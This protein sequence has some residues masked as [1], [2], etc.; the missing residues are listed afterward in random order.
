MGHALAKLSERLGYHRA[1]NSFEE[2]VSEIEFLKEKIGVSIPLGGSFPTNDSKAH[3]VLY[4]SD[5][6]TTPADATKAI[7]IDARIADRT[8]LINV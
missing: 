4:S 5:V 8:K 3:F 2:L 1:I 7:E 6:S